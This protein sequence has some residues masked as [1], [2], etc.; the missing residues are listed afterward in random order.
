[1]ASTTDSGIAHAAEPADGPAHLN[2]VHLIGVLASVEVRTLPSGDELLG[3]RVTVRRPPPV[4]RGR[5]AAPVDAPVRR[6][7]TVDAIECI[8]GTP[9]AAR[10]VRR[11]EPGDI[12]EVSGRLQRRFW[13]SPAG[14]ASTYQVEAASARRVPGAR[15][16]QRSTS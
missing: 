10:G 2:D 3:F 1:M 6:V 5:R 7:P 13:R 14:P 9:A 4:P 8:A 11:C 15:S 12:V 16:R